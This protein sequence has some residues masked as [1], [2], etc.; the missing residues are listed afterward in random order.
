VIRIGVAVMLVCA[1]AGGFA[2]WRTHRTHDVV[3]SPTVEFTTTDAPA[4]KPSPSGVLEWP[5]Y[6]AD[7]Q[8]TRAV[9]GVRLAPPFRRLWT[10]HGRALLEFPPAVAGDRLYLPTFD[11]RF[12][13]LD[14]ATGHAVWR[15]RSGRCSWAS[16][17]LAG[18]LVYET[19]LSAPDCRT[20]RVRRGGELIAFE[21]RT[22]RVRWRRRI[23]PSESSPLVREGRVVVGDWNGD[24][25]AYAARTGRT[26]WRA[27]LG[28]AVKGSV[29]ASGNRLFIGAYDGRVYALSAASGRVIWRASAESAL[30]HGAKFYSSP[31]VAYGRV[32]IG[33]TDGV[34]YSFGAGSG[35][36]RWAR[37]TGGYVY[38]SPAVA[39]GRVF[40]GSYDHWF[41]ALDAATGAVRWRFHANGPISGAATV[42]GRT[43]WFS[44]F[45]GRTYALDTH[46]GARRWSF[47]DGKYSPAVTDGARLYIVGLGRLYA[48][49]GG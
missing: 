1:V 11:G 13:A 21:S 32:Y 48:F 30:F 39:E 43:V 14:A 27:R 46:A 10:F 34:L 49:T 15:F 38:A 7:A 33:G 42:I 12:Y 19:F 47:P 6:G 41:Y 44:T 2:V 40:V 23:A 22:G 31:A 5:T 29:A 4:A 18:G 26:L 8:R 9:G 37:R 20:E 35:R 16:P 36:L 25:T 24:V 45:A 28:G 3:G 17:A